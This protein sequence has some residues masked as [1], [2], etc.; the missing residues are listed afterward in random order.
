MK[1][2]PLKVGDKFWELNDNHL[3]PVIY[4]R[5]AHSPQHIMYCMDRLGK[6]TFLTQEDAEQALEQ[7]K[8]K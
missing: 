1:R 6:W 4:P 5:I 2:L 3:K 7:M 8:D